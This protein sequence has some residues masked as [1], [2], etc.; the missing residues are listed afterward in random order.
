MYKPT[1]R[2][3]PDDKRPSQPPSLNAT[4][5]CCR[6]A[7][8]CHLQTDKLIQTGLVCRYTRICNYSTMNRT[9]VPTLIWLAPL[10][11]P[12]RTFVRPP[13]TIRCQEWQTADFPGG[14]PLG[15]CNITWHGSN[16]EVGNSFFTVSIG[17][18]T[19][20]RTFIRKFRK[21]ENVFFN[22]RCK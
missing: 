21:Y 3:I 18:T 12:P 15:A 8:V 20:T 16:T 14:T 1:V 4:V 11:F 9:E 22:G 2:P 17:Y 7:L 6:H 13:V 19:V 10:M 5:S